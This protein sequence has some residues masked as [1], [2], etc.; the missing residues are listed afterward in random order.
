MIQ[1]A[2]LFLGCV[3]FLR[4][5]LD[6]YVCENRFI[7]NGFSSLDLENLY[8]LLS[9]DQFFTSLFLAPHSLLESVGKLV[10]V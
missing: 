4:H 5:S 10:A 2:N 7:Q 6:G 9:P 8:M 3:G 1:A